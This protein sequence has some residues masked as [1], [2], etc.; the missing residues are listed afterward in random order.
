MSDGCLVAVFLSCV[1]RAS[2]YHN[3]ELRNG[4]FIARIFPATKLSLISDEVA[5]AVVVILPADSALCLGLCRLPRLRGMFFLFLVAP[6]PPWRLRSRKGRRAYI[7]H[8][9]RNP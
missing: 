1:P 6:K 3:Q 7:N 8:R 9:L 4:S 2:R 5:M